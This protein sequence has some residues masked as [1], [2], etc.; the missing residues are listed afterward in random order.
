MLK[1]IWI[2]NLKVEI[3]LDVTMKLSRQESICRR[4]PYCSIYPIQNTNISTWENFTL[5]GRQKIAKFS[6]DKL[7]ELA[8]LKTLITQRLDMC[9]SV[10][11]LFKKGSYTSQFKKCTYQMLI[12]YHNFNLLEISKVG[13]IWSKKQR[14]I[15]CS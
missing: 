15:L 14:T 3:N 10:D 4:V 7:N 9:M 2:L 1:L 11:Q 12:N 13:Q 8:C 6:E 5:L